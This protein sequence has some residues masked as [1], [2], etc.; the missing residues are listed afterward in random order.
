MTRPPSIPVDLWDAIP[1]TLQPAIAA[2]VAGLEARNARLEARVADLEARLIQTSANSSRPPSA[3]PPHAKPAP[4]RPPSGKR[5]G[6]QPGHPK[7]ERVLLPPD[8]I[9]HHKPTRCRRCAGRLAGDDPAPLAHQV[10]D[11]P[12]VR[13]HVTE[14]RRHRLTCPGCGAVTCAPV[15]TD[16][17]T[18]YGP[19]ARAVCALLSGGCRLGKR[20]VSQLMGDLFGLPVSPAAVCALQADTA[21]ALAPIHAAA[22]DF[23][24]TQ[25]AN[26]DETGWTQGRTKA[27]LWVAVTAP[28][29]AFLLRLTRGRTA[30]DD[31]VGGTPPVL[32]T[33]RYGVYDHLPTARRQVCWA[34]LRR[35]FQAM[36]DRR[37][38]GAGIGEELLAHADILL[39][40]WK[41][42]RDGTLSPE[43]F[44][45]SYL[46]WVR[47]E[48]RGLLA[49]GAASGCAKTAA[50][51]REV[52]GV[53]AALWTFADVPGVEPTNNAAERAVRHAV[54]WRKTSYGTDSEAGS[55]FVERI[56]TVIASCRQQGRSVLEFLTA[57]VQA[58]RIGATPPSLIPAG[59]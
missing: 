47:A 18:G 12:L 59:A 7:H 36:I 30:F 9:L 32:T 35:D 43:G 17:A 28:V 15:P 53:E 49:R 8:E 22:L 56:L 33:D 24:R 51:C 5:R 19:R 46:S 58:A 40:Q 48:V 1:P 29:T 54:C 10:H 27:W 34:H 55:R 14:H 38:A 57:A 42:V 31:L 39:R 41:R 6:G 25:P 23:T 11:V 3:D 4:P 26:V 45:R 37:N 13:P 20:A 16:A 52:L 2:V 50:T 44:R 21:A